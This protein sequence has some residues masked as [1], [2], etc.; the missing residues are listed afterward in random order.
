M[1]AAEFKDAY[2]SVLKAFVESEEEQYLAKAG[3]L[4]RELVRA[5]LPPEEIAEIH[6]TAIQALAEE[7]PDKTLLEMASRISSPL[8]ELLMAY[9]LAFREQQDIERKTQQALRR[10]QKME[11]VGQLAGGIAHDFNNILQAMMGHVEFAKKGLSPD[12]ERFQDIAEILKCAEK[13]AALTRQL[14]MFSR[15]Q[16]I[17]PQDLNLS[18]VIRNV[19]KMIRRTIGENID[20]DFVPGPSLDTVHVD[21]V[22][23]EQVVMNLCLNAR[24]AM[25][26]GGKLSIETE[27]VVVNG[28]YVRAHPWA[29]EGRYVLLSITDTGCGMDEETLKHVFEPFFTTKETGKGT[30]LGLATVYGIVKQHKG[31]LHVYSE[32]G[33]GTMFKLYFPIVERRSVEVARSVQGPVRGGTETI[34]L[35]ED[36]EN[37][38]R[39]AKRTLENAGYTVRTATDGLEAIEV[40]QAHGEEI[41]LVLS[42]VVMPK[43]DGKEVFHRIKD[44]NREQ[45]ILFTTGYSASAIH[46]RFVLEEGLKLIQKPY[47][48]ESL[49][50]KVREVLDA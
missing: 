14:L 5:G 18:D 36:D 31:F 15:R 49:L 40:F 28:E 10:A 12:E 20:L 46:T 23:I 39:M 9:G 41:T 17:E 47:S 30:G 4:G 8:L 38:R 42:D 43:L 37:V 6:E 16:I 1:D 13:A 32:V 34:L 35:A 19:L 45:R 11:A 33:K 44:A 50:R 3:E 22:Q 25:P 48:P 2:T 29:K 26:R 27:N 24:D 7:H 21:P